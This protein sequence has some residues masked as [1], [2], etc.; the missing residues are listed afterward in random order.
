MLITNFAPGVTAA[1]RPSFFFSSSSSSYRERDNK[2]IPLLDH[3]PPVNSNNWSPSLLSCPHDGE[4]EARTGREKE[5]GHL[6]VQE[7]NESERCNLPVE[8]EM[9]ADGPNDIEDA[10]KC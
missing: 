2:H 7:Q 9:T 6:L 3:Y 10:L 8:K 4:E 1:L 5:V